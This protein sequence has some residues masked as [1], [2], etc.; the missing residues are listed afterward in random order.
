M[1]THS[2]TVLVT[3]AHGTSF[4][5]CIQ[6]EKKHFR[7]TQLLPFLRLYKIYCVTVIFPP[8]W[9]TLQSLK[10]FFCFSLFFLLFHRMI[11]TRCFPTFDSLFNDDTRVLSNT[12]TSFAAVA[13]AFPSNRFGVNISVMQRYWM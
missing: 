1:Q 8:Q 13:T 10:R 2:H 11:F 7:P 9:K 4:T 12:A 6:G 5:G 3:W